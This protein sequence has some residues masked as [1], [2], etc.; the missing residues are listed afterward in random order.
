MPQ[1]QAPEQFTYV[2]IPASNSD[3]MEE[4][5]SKKVSLEE[6]TFISGLKSWF[7]CR[8]TND[9]IDMAML[10]KQMEHHAKQELKLDDDAMKHILEQSSCDIFPVQV[11][12]KEFGYFAV[13]LYCDD[14][15][16]AKGLEENSRA[17]GLVRAC[18]YVD[19]TIRG[20]CFLSRIF[21]D[22]DAWF[23]CDFKLS[24]MGSDVPWVVQ[25]RETRSK[26]GNAQSLSNLTANLA[27]NAQMIA[28]QMADT[29]GAMEVDEEGFKWKQDGEEVEITGRLPDGTGKK[30]IKV[31]FRPK[32]CKIL[33]KGAVLFGGALGGSVEADECTW[34]LGS[35]G[36]GPYIQLTLPKEGDIRWDKCFSG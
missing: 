9:K 12:M 18:G 26:K 7:S 23:R 28:P 6:D 24:D 21:D 8:N 31:E 36:E 25:T 10:K 20:D 32:S 5:T 14:K 11:P 29:G 4:M 34:T 22:E 16:I 2:F 17:T 30:D 35:D 33:V 1:P 15:G 3:A 27:P 13:S 19:Q